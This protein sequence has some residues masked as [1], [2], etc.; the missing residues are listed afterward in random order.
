MREKRLKQLML[1][2]Y[3]TFEKLPLLYIQLES[4]VAILRVGTTDQVTLGLVFGFDVPV[5]FS[6]AAVPGG[7]QVDK[8]AV[9]HLS[10]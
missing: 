2:L 4:V 3:F 8:D 1:V 10:G 5:T 6:I 9:V 7:A